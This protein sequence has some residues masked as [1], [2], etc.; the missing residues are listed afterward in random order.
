MGGA[1]NFP[2]LIKDMNHQNTEHFDLL[3]QGK[4]S[5]K[6]SSTSKMNMWNIKNLKK[7]ILFVNIECIRLTIA[8]STIES[9]KELNNIIRSLRENNCVFRSYTDQ[10]KMKMNKKTFR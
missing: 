10:Q 3:I 2:E 8:M 9:R 1:E 5:K 4:I 6:K 7:K